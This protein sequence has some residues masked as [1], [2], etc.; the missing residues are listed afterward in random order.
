[1]DI[2]DQILENLELERELG[3]RTVEIDRALLVPPKPAP[4][5]PPPEPA[6]Q[7][8]Q[9]PALKRPVPKPAERGVGCDIA[10]FTGR[11][12]SA[13][14]LEAMRKTV[15][16]MKRVKA[17]VNVCVNEERNAKVIVLLGSDALKKRMPQTR[18]V[19]GKW[20]TLDGV[21]AVMTF[22]PDFILTHFQDGSPG[23][24]AAKRQMWDDI[25][26]AMANLD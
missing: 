21:P 12:L 19:R 5:P 24:N 15:A 1:M 7:P 23:M 6:P 13:A 9:A 16:A 17:D 11:S 25:K 10:F 20:I 18:P 4:P 3:T 22:S 8:P 14:G 26:S 2:F